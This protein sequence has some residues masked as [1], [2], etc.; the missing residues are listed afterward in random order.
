VEDDPESED[1]SSRNLGNTKETFFGAASIL[2]CIG[3]VPGGVS[4]ENFVLVARFD[5]SAVKPLPADV[6]R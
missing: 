6:S 2:M 5:K 4:F 1:A 3:P